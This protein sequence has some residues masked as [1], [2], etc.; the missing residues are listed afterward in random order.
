MLLVGDVV[1]QSDRDDLE[2]KYT[3]E[4]EVFLNQFLTNIKKEMLNQLELLKINIKSLKDE[5]LEFKFRSD[6][7]V[8]RYAQQFDADD[9]YEWI[10]K[11]TCHAAATALISWFKEMDIISQNMNPY[12]LRENN[13]GDAEEKMAQPFSVGRFL[14]RESKN[15]AL[16]EFTIINLKS[17]IFLVQADMYRNLEVSAPGGVIE[18]S[19][20]VTLKQ[21]N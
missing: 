12:S 14:I 2:L 15:A 21:P 18:I 5:K 11:K 9:A 8:E 6:S 20:E 7:V 19:N 10:Y 4:Y 13:L 1:M 16:H 17:K 3:K